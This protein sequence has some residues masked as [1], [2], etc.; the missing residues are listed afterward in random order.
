MIWVCLPAS[1][2]SGNLEGKDTLDWMILVILT[3]KMYYARPT[4]RD[5]AINGITCKANATWIAVALQKRKLYN[6]KASL[7][8]MGG[9]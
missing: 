4:H 7:A 9:C 3:Q 1:I 8:T 5:L 2:A 6:S